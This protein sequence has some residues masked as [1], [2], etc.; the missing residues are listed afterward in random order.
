[1]PK[2]TDTGNLQIIWT[3]EA[4]GRR[5]N[6][7]GAFVRRKLVNM[8]DSPVHRLDGKFWAFEDELVSFFARH[9]VR[10]KP[11]Q[12]TSIHSKP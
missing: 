8:P 1:M 3:A 9:A 7:S 12:S 2:L 5:I 11:R 4:I 10:T 6:G